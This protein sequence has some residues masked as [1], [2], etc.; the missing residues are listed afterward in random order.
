MNR[1]GRK[2]KSQQEIHQYWMEERFQVAFDDFGQCDLG[3]PSCY[4]CGTWS[5]D[6]VWTFERAHLIDRCFDGLDGVQ[7][8]VLL[9]DLCHWSMPSFAPG[10]EA[11]AIAWVASRPTYLD[12]MRLNMEAAMRWIERAGEPALQKW[13][14]NTPS[15]MRDRVERAVRQELAQRRE[16]A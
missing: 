9:C 8:L 11:L 4:G 7:N 5:K 2:M 16:L 3:E 14:G 15:D 12:Q 10:E 1:P 13:L 6:R